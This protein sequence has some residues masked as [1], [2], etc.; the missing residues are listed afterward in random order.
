[1]RSNHFGSAYEDY[2]IICCN[3]VL[4]GICAKAAKL[5]KPEGRTLNGRCRGREVFYLKIFSMHQ[6]CCLQAASSMHYT[7]CCKHSIA[8]LRMDEIIARNMLSWWKLLIKSLF[9]HLVGCLYYCIN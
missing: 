3:A 4:F 7:T 6:R 2:G 5:Q 8:L 1:V 9:L